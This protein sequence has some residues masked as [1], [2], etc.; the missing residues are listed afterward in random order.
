MKDT[1]YSLIKED[2]D[3]YNKSL[4]KNNSLLYFIKSLEKETPFDSNLTNLI[5][6]IL[7]SKKIYDLNKSFEKYTEK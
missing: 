7:D 5:T 6:F 3:D 1:F 2:V 4:I